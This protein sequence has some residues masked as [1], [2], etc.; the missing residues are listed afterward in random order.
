M[1]RHLHIM[2]W[3]LPVWP[4]LQGAAGSRRRGTL[5]MYEYHML[6]CMSSF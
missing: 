6:T 1:M 3:Q 5:R 4:A 2:H